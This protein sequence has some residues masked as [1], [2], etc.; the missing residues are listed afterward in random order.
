MSLGAAG[1]FVVLAG[2]AMGSFA[3]LLAERL[4]R[5]EP[6]SWKWGCSRV[7]ATTSTM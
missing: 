6:P 5:G 1:L 3:A 7:A 2:P 4:P